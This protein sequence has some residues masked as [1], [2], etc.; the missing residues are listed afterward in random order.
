[1]RKINV[2]YTFNRTFCIQNLQNFIH[3]PRKSNAYIL[4]SEREMWESILKF[5]ASLIVI[6]PRITWAFL[7]R[8]Y[9]PIPFNFL[10]LRGVLWFCFCTLIA[11]IFFYLNLSPAKRCLLQPFALMC[12]STIHLASSMSSPICFTLLYIATYFLPPKVS[13][14]KLLKGSWQ[15][16]CFTFCAH[17]SQRINHYYFTRK[18]L[19][20]LY[21]V[22][23]GCWFG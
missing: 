5:T 23:C 22:S 6:K 1:M 3:L 20:L 10:Q 13:A 14:W 7:S 18:V 2:Q 21:S 11:K 8:N 4:I 15:I 9:F 19:Y 12:L 17:G 16:H